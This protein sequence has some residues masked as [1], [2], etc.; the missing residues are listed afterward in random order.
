MAAPQTNARQ[1]VKAK[2]TFDSKAY[3]DR[4]KEQARHTV[5]VTVEDEDDNACQPVAWQREGWAALRR[6]IEH[7][8]ATLRPQLVHLWRCV[9]VEGKPVDPAQTNPQRPA[10]RVPAQPWGEQR[11]RGLVSLSSQPRVRKHST[12]SAVCCVDDK[13]LVLMGGANWETELLKLPLR[14]LCVKVHAD[15]VGCFSLKIRARSARQ[16]DSR[17]FVFVES[18]DVRDEWL[19]TLYD[20]KVEVRGWDAETCYCPPRPTQGGHNPRVI[21]LS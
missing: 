9:D 10:H 20:R 5:V 6:D 8:A 1:E 4:H 17:L 19:S 14:H 18:Q 7:A 11:F 3:A 12:T 2:C 15:E 16:E 21:W 13:D